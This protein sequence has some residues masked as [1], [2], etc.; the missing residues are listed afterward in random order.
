MCGGGEALLCSQENQE[1]WNEH[2]L[3]AAPDR[4][5]VQLTGTVKV[6]SNGLNVPDT[7]HHQGVN[8][9][10]SDHRSEPI[11]PRWA[12]GDQTSAGCPTLRQAGKPLSL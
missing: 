2:V 7:L 1:D 3:F 10:V 12:S 5:E 6:H 9:S 8:F 11:E 4:T